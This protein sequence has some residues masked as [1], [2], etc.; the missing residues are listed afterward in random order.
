MFLPHTPHNPP[1]R[2]LGKYLT[3]DRPERIAKYYATVEWL[4]ETVGE[5]LDFLDKANRPNTLVLYVADN[6]W[7]TTEDRADQSTA[8]AKMSPYEMGVRTPI[9][10]RWPGKVEPGRDDRTLVSGIDLVPTMLEA[11]GIE[12]SADL[13]GISLLDRKALQQRKQ[14]FGSTFAHTAVN[15]LDPVANLKYGTVVREDGW[16]LVLPYALNRD[17]MHMIRGQIADWMRFEPE[18]Y[19][20]LE[21]PHETNDLAAEHP[22]LVAELREALQDWWPVPEELPAT[23]S[24]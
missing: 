23:G 13:P 18:L 5:L 20:V 21:D 6:G 1:E 16:K 8:R 19:N 24:E 7:I 11:A 3:Q 2:L 4:D 15:V 10:I 12:P 22:D 17:V 9:M 14:V